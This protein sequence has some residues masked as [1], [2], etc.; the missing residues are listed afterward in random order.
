ST[1]VSG[2]LSKQTKVMRGID[3]AKWKRDGYFEEKRLTAPGTKKVYYAELEDRLRYN[4][5]THADK[6]TMP[7][8]LIVGSKDDGTP[9]AHQKL[10]MDA[11]A[12]KNKEIHIIDGSEHSYI[13][14]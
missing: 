8:L 3:L 10:L 9:Y 2:E 11:S 4:L 5:L 13:A 6:L 12:S 14:P 7:L 1:V